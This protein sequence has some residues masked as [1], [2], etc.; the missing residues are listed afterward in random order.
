MA[1]SFQNE[2]ALLSLTTE[3]DPGW[4]TGFVG[5][6]EQM[7]WTPYRNYIRTNK[8]APGIASRGRMRQ[9]ASRTLHGRS[10]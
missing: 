5:H 3:E 7:L 9:S 10:A 1:P 6:P 4:V 2:V 8:N